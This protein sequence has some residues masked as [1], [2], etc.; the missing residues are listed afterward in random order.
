V[1]SA[2][3]PDRGGRGVGLGNGQGP[4]SK[5]EK[6]FFKL[7]ADELKLLEK[8]PTG[9]ALLSELDLSGKVVTIFA[10]EKGR[11]SV[12]TANP[13]GID[14]EVKC[15]IKPFRPRHK[16]LTIGMRGEDPKTSTQVKGYRDA[17]A[18]IGEDKKKA[19]L[20]GELD[21]I[22]QR[23]GVTRKALAQR[24]NRHLADVDAMIAGTQAVDDDSYFRICFWFYDHLTPG[25][26]VDTAIRL[27]PVDRLFDDVKSEK[28]KPKLNFND[29]PGHILLGHEL[30]HAWRMMAG[31]RVVRQGWEEEA[32]T[33]G[34]SLFTTYRFTENRLRQEAGLP[35]RTNY[36]HQT[37]SSGLALRMKT[38]DGRPF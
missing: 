9:R 17:L 37:F 20:A 10:A 28:F 6:A 12:T 33:T 7:V 11:D 1:V 3:D 15:S 36:P 30:I 34:I 29:V 18:T 24:L 32:M 22:L 19:A 8:L 38:D 2:R 25:A 5:P 16:N 23:A 31:R 35:T 14:A 13:A 27:E 26:G 4:D 21:V